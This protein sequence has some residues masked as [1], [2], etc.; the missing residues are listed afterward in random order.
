M[1]VLKKERLDIMLGFDNIFDKIKEISA[2]SEK[3]EQGLQDSLAKEA[4]KIFPQTATNKSKDVYFDLWL[5]WK[6]ADRGCTKEIRV[7]RLE[8][9]EEGELVRVTRMLTITIPKG[10]G[11]QSILRLKEHGNTCKNG[12]KPGDLFVLLLVPEDDK[13]KRYNDRNND[14]FTN[15]QVASKN[16]NRDFS[17]ILLLKTDIQKIVKGDTFGEDLDLDLEI[18]FEDATLGC[19]REIEIPRLEMT[20]TGKLDRVTK[21]LKVKITAG[22]KHGSILRLREQGDACR[23]GGKSGDL[24]LFLLVLSKDKECKQN[25][26]NIDPK[27]KVNESHPRGEDIRMDLAI[28]FDD[29]ILGCEREIQIPR[30]EMT[31]EGELEYIIKSLKVTIPMGISHGSKL[32][33]KGQG[34]ACMYGGKPGD[35]YLHLLVPSQDKDRKRNGINIES[36]I[37]ITSLQASAGCEIVVNTT[38]GW[39]TI[40]VSPGTKTGDFLVLSGC[41]VYQQGSP[42]KNGD[43]IIKF[44]CE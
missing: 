12:S 4:R 33:L 20:E 7:P 1:F 31:D 21:S 15:F 32:R 38:T 23:Y 17:K 43:Y 11:H 9:T 24:Y 27:I 13:D 6:D 22:A 30:S 36:E 3:W 34:H 2:A 40:F 16:F 39:R 29:A 42:S 41:G 14:I 35:L 10:Q 37:K 44:V 8:Y 5:S 26:V 28:G 25:D 19:D 18:E